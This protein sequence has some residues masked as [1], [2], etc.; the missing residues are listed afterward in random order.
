MTFVYWKLKTTIT[1]SIIICPKLINWGCRLYTCNTAIWHLLTC[2]G[3]YQGRICVKVGIHEQHRAHDHSWNWP[4][5]NL[6]NQR[7]NRRRSS[8]LNDNQALR[9]R[10]IAAVNHLTWAYVVLSTF[11]NPIERDNHSDPLP[12]WWLLRRSHRFQPHNWALVWTAPKTAS[13]DPKKHVRTVS[14][15]ERIT[16]WKQ[17]N[18]SFL[19]TVATDIG[20]S[21]FKGTSP[22]SGGKFTSV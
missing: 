13:D 22:K 12:R 3:S 6:P 2:S 19:E 15:T 21:P 11:T 20:L 4:N 18:T 7:N 17:E 1:L 5:T 16:R 9:C 14:K 8:Q 10:N